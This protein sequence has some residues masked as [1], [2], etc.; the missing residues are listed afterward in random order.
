MQK[1]KTAIKYRI[2]MNKIAIIIPIL[3]EVDAIHRLLNSK[4][5]AAL[6]KNGFIDKM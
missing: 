3:N 6:L 5:I 4:K 1:Q 2:G